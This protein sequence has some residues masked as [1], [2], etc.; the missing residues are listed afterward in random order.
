MNIKFGFK[1]IWLKYIF[2]K[3]SL[4]I[5]DSERLK[6]KSIELGANEQNIFISMFGVDVN[7]YKNKRQILHI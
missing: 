3:S 7:E 5:C 6:K 1:K 2:T 4:I